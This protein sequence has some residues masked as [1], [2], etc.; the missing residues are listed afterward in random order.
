MRLHEFQQAEDD[1]PDEN[2]GVESIAN[3]ITVL[4]F[5]MKRAQDE[6]ADP[7]I[8][9]QALIGMVKNTGVPYDYAALVNAHE[10]NAAVQNLISDYN[11]NEITLAGAPEDELE[12]GKHGED[13]QEAIGRIAKRVATRNI[14]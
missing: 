3:L 13:G 2:V 5:V 1:L 10:T 11:E 12:P 7:I 6:G 9:T 8:S 14:K 4:Q